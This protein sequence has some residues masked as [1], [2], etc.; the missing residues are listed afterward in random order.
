MTYAELT[1]LASAYLENSET[2]FV[3][4]LPSIINQAEN[5]IYHIV[6]TPDQRLVDTGSL[7]STATTITAPAAFLEP[8]ALFVTTA[9][10][11]TTPLLQKQ[12]SWLLTVFNATTDSGTPAYYAI[13]T[14]AAS[15][16][17]I[18]VGPP[19]DATYTYTLEYFGN[20]KSIVS[21]SSTWLSV[22]YPEALLY[23]T[24]LEGY[25]YMKGEKDM[26]DTFQ[27]R[28]ES[29]MGSLKND[30]DVQELNDEYRN[31]P[32]EREA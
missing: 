2:G 23:A 11:A 21:E 8:Q 7:A 12:L 29:A 3:A 17:S 27:Q 25:V 9:G 24:L 6:N 14:A 26:R 10:G 30:A 20:P 5:R 19:A 16:T 1:S 31:A 13:K 4:N 18:V 15:T 22:Q 32:R 28:F